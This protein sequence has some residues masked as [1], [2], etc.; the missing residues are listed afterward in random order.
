MWSVSMRIL[1]AVNFL[2]LAALSTCSTPCPAGTVQGRCRQYAVEVRQAHFAQFGTDYPWHYALGQLQQES[3]CRNVISGDGV[4]SQGVSQVTWSFWG[5]YLK[6][7]DIPDLAT[8]RNQIRAQA[9]INRDA[10]NQARPKRLWIGYQIYNGGRL[11][12]QEIKAAGVAEWSAARAQCRRK[13]VVFSSG[14]R[15]DACQINY[16]YSQKLAA[17]GDQYRLGPDSPKFIYW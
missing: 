11:V 3:G 10:W 8:P 13:V 17:Y 2:L 1:W 14:Q 5:R 9:Y 6:Q 16:D 12:L 7:V 4:G 15:V